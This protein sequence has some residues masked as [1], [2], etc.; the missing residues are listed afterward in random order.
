[1]IRAVLTVIVLTGAVLTGGVG[2]ITRTNSVPLAI[3]YTNPPPCAII[4]SSYDLTNWFCI[5]RMQRCDGLTNGW[6]SISWSDTAD[7]PNQFW[8]VRPCP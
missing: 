5:A 7:G 4:E 6:N 8:R 3:A 1:M 2:T